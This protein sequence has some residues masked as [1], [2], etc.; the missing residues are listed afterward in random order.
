VSTRDQV[1]TLIII[2]QRTY[3]HTRFFCL[4]YVSSHLGTWEY[5]AS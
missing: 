2:L 1:Y 4:S 5:W 3:M